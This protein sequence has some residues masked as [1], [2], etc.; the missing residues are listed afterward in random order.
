GATWISLSRSA[1]PYQPQ[2]IR[3]TRLASRQVKPEAYLPPIE[4]ANPAADEVWKKLRRFIVVILIPIGLEPALRQKL[5]PTR[6]SFSARHL[7]RTL[8]GATRLVHGAENFGWMG[9]KPEATKRCVRRR[10]DGGL[11]CR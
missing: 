1:L 11:F 10:L 4:N 8:T 3:P 5:W 2:P 6:C 7:R 9:R